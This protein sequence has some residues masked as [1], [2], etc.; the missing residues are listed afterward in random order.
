MD[1]FSK[2][3]ITKIRDLFPQ[4]EPCSA[5][6]AGLSRTLK[7]SEAAKKVDPCLE[8]TKAPTSGREDN[9]LCRHH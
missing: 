5:S 8:P 4:G 2:G 6:G 1:W 9:T 3:L 7:S